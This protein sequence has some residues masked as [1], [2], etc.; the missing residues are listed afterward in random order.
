MVQLLSD[1]LLHGSA[2][3]TQQSR[4]VHMFGDS[5]R[6]PEY[7]FISTSHLAQ[8]ASPYQYCNLV[9]LGLIQSECTLACSSGG[10]FVWIVSLLF[11]ISLYFY[12]MY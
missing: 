1:G 8:V 4:S 11:L 2:A 12:L 10:V 6:H 9:S 5:P 7:L 3:L